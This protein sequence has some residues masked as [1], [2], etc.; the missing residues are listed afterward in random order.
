MP[1][2][3]RAWKREPSLLSQ[4]RAGPLIELSEWVHTKFEIFPTDKF[5]DW[6]VQ[7]I[8]GQAACTV[9][10]KLKL[11]SSLLRGPGAGRRPAEPRFTYECETRYILREAGDWEEHMNIH[12]EKLK[13]AVGRAPTLPVL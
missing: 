8:N 2:S 9:N 12:R 7:L 10:S 4:S 13:E 1:R 3:R 11:F 6:E 5:E